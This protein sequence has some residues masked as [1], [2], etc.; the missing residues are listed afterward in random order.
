[1]NA[2]QTRYKVM[3]K[4]FRELRVYQQAFKAAMRIYELSKGWPPEERFSLTDQIRRASRSVCINISEAWR[5]RRYERH[6]VSKLSDADTETA[7]TQGWLDFALACHYISRKDYEELDQE[8]ESISGGLVKMMTHPEQWCGP[9][10]LIQEEEAEYRATP[11]SLPHPHTPI[12][13]NNE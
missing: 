13:P 3:V 9:S 12:L 1:M 8:Y 6:F 11:S 4:H 10:N 2:R 7:E 5:K